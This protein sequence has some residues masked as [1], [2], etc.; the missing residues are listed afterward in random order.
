MADP[1]LW[2]RVPENRCVFMTPVAGSVQEVGCRLFGLAAIVQDC[3]TDAEN[4][5]GL[6]VSIVTAD[7]EPCVFVDQFP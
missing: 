3:E 2:T 4:L 1:K 5:A 7:F 6:I